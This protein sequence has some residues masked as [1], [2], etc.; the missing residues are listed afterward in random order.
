MQDKEVQVGWRIPATLKDQLEK[1]AK[2]DGRSANAEAIVLMQEALTLRSG[3]IRSWIGVTA[4][5]LGYWDDRSQNQ[6]L[7]ES[8]RKEAK[9]CAAD[10]RE[11]LLGIARLDDA[12]RKVA[13]LPK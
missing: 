3:S 5:Q 12:A 1:A 11:F 2:N 8:D 9:R 4:K 6:S 7:S 13:R 10:F